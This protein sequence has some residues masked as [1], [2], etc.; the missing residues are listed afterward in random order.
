[1]A[2]SILK[3]TQN[4]ES[5]MNG[6]LCVYFHLRRIHNLWAERSDYYTRYDIFYQMVFYVNTIRKLCFFLTLKK[7]P[8]GVILN[9]DYVFLDVT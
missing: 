9:M 2:T 7:T 4:V 3:S 6:L 8:I 5:Y 1:M